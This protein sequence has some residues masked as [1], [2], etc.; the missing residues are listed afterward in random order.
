MSFLF[1]NVC[2]QMHDYAKKL[3]SMESKD[4]FNCLQ[5]FRSTRTEIEDK[6]IISAKSTMSFIHWRR[7]I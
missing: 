1:E 7:R 5:A 2:M 6:T 3:F 4:V